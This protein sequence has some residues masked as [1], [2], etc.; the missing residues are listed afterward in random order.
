[1]GNK[2]NK[3]IEITYQ[4]HKNIAMNKIIFLFLNRLNE[5]RLEWLNNL[6]NYLNLQR[7]A[8]QFEICFFLSGESLYSLL[9]GRT[10]SLWMNLLTNPLIKLYVD[11]IE[12][13]II[14]IPIN[15]LEERYS[16]SIYLTPENLKIGSNFW[17]LLIGKIWN[18]S[19]DSR[20]GILQNDGPYM[21]R[22]SVYSVRLMNA[23]LNKEFNT[24]F[25]G[26]LDGVHLGHKGQN[27]S[28][29]ENISRALLDIEHKA[30]ENKLEF[31]MLSCSRC[32]TARGYIRSQLTQEL[33][34]SD[35]TIP[36]YYFCNLN[37]IVTQFEKQHPI[38]SSNSAVITL[39][40]QRNHSKPSLIIFLTHNPYS[41]EWTFGGISFAVASATHNISTQVIFIEDG[42]YGLIGKHQINEEDKIFNLQDIIEATADMENLEFYG[43]IPSFKKR[44]ISP[45]PQLESLSLIDIGELANIILKYNR[46][47]LYHKRIIFF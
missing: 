9:D 43:Y 17:E 44:N 28:E 14:G 42:I 23:A 2:D 18:D 11:H 13:Q 36:H 47:G 6:F 34:S 29:F 22:T 45:S 4:V 25:Y 26:Y 46:K 32:G 15:L 12:L 10:S 37:K 21:H 31:L 16:N 38:I 30:N 5:E 33:Y 7:D 27:P 1:L 8:P 24:E 19:F 20:I 3:E 39:N 41:S 35:D 40:F